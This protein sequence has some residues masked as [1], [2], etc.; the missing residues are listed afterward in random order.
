MIVYAFKLISPL[1]NI[2][3]QNKAGKLT[4]EIKQEGN[5]V[6]YKRELVLNSNKIV[7][8]RDLLSAPLCQINDFYS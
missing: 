1:K 5:I 7:T 3:L 4:I 8:E 2:A 6:N